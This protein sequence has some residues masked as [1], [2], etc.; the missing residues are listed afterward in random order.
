MLHGPAGGDVDV[1]QSL[2][3]PR[4]LARADREREVDVAAIRSPSS[5]SPGRPDPQPRGRAAGQPDAVV[6]TRDDVAAEH[7][8][9]GAREAREVGGLERELAD[10]PRNALQRGT[11][12][13]VIGERVRSY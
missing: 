5:F 13:E 2:A 10:S 7:D 1:V 4:Q 11:W 9:V 8:A 6:L 12:L 3:E